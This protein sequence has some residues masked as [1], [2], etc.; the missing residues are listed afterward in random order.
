MKVVTNAATVGEI[1]KVLSSQPERPA[2]VRIFV[3][4][5]G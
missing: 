3:A 1:Q 5:Y 2:I 4:G